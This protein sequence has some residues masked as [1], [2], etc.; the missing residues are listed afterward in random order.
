MSLGWSN[1][2]RIPEAGCG[3]VW[4][5]RELDNYIM[6]V[7]T[8]W[9]DSRAWKVCYPVFC[10][11]RGGVSL[12]DGSSQFPQEWVVLKKE[13]RV[14]NLPIPLIL[15][16]DLFLLCDVIWYKS[17]K[18]SHLGDR[19][20]LSWTSVTTFHNQLS[21]FSLFFFNRKWTNESIIIFTQEERRE[22][23]ASYNW[24]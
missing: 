23:D 22:R 7:D 24:E 18:Q 19:Y 14:L 4:N 11:L 13:A 9:I 10:Y 17:L 1:V 5:V 15:P 6:T 2:W 16:D 12:R 8:V 3:S 20:T 21:N